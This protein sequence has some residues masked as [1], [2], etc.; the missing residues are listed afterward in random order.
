MAINVKRSVDHLIQT[1][2]KMLL[3]WIPACAGMTWCKFFDLLYDV[4]FS[5]LIKLKV[6]SDY[7]KCIFLNMTRRESKK[8]TRHMNDM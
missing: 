8:L 4:I 2:V 1:V 5:V 7:L 3:D 6:C